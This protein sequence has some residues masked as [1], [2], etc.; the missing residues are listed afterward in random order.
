MKTAILALLA[1]MYFSMP[2]HAKAD[3]TGSTYTMNSAYSLCMANTDVTIS[4]VVAAPYN[5]ATLMISNSAASAIR[6]YWVAP[7]R[8]VGT[9]TKNQFSL[10]GGKVV[11]IKVNMVFPGLTTYAT[12]LEHDVPLISAGPTD[13]IPELL[14]YKLSEGSQSYQLGLRFFQNSPV[15]L[16]DSSLRGGTAGTVNATVPVEWDTNQT[17]RPF[18]AIH[19]NGNSTA[20]D[21]HNGTDFNFTTNL[22]TLNVWVRPLVYNCIVAG[23]GQ[24]QNSGWYCWINPYGSIGLSAENPGADNYVWTPASAVLLG[25]WSMLTLVRTGTSTV[26]IYKNA[27]LQQTSGSFRDPTSCGDSLLFGGYHG[28]GIHYDGD[29]GE[30]RTYNRVLSIEEINAL[31]IYGIIQ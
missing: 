10:P 20:L 7:G 28:G 2:D 24:Y 23:N 13:I 22:F 11:E 6:V 19:F 4:N 26:S 12:L 29:L 8:A 27:V 1:A 21:T 15:N 9:E 30:V 17:A 25:E 18:S 14:Y 5:A 16:T 31:F 3:F